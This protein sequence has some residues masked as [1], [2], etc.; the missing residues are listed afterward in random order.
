MVRPKFQW[1]S[2][3]HPGVGP[4]DPTAPLTTTIASLD[5]GC[6]NLHLGPPRGWL[7]FPK[8]PM[9]WEISSNILAKKKLWSILMYFFKGRSR[10]QGVV[11]WKCKVYWGVLTCQF[12]I[13]WNFSFD[14]PWYP[15][16]LF[17]SKECCLR[18]FATNRTYQKFDTILEHFDMRLQRSLFKTLKIQQHTACLSGLKKRKS[19]SS[20][21]PLPQAVRHPNHPES[22]QEMEHSKLETVAFY[23]TKMAACLVFYRVSRCFM[24]LHWCTILSINRINSFRQTIATSH[25][26]V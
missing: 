26:K 3:Q 9:I 24:S 15:L 18:V 7:K 13:V 16:G 2:H 19:N 4:K 8:N 25:L 12:W 11:L 21:V 6:V 14:S 10:H 23:L 22:I 1:P 5:E 17:T 20:T